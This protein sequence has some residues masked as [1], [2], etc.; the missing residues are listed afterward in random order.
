MSSWQTSEP[1]LLWCPLAPTAVPYSSCGP[2]Q[3]C[4]SSGRVVL[5]GDLALVLVKHILFPVVNGCLCYNLKLVLWVS[6]VFTA[7]L[8]FLWVRVLVVLVHMCKS[9]SYQ[10]I[11]QA[12]MTYFGQILTLVV[13][14]M[15]SI[16]KISIRIYQF[17][18]NQPSVHIP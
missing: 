15:H 18:I 4:V 8:L 2:H 3:F 14:N 17:I 13:Y 1:C 7:Y 5:N 9:W 10:C 6:L 12:N 16:C 11:S